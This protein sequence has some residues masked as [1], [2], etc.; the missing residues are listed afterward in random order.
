[1]KA[2]RKM[3]AQNDT[4]TDKNQMKSLTRTGSAT[5]YGLNGT[6]RGKNYTKEP[7]LRAGNMGNTSNGITAGRRHLNIGI[8]KG[9]KMVCG[10]NGMRMVKKYI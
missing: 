6:K 1:M 5:V 7:I 9:K 8:M 2:S 4:Q 10:W 3:S